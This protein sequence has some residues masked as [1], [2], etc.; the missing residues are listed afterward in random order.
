MS[1]MNCPHCHSEDIVPE[2]V[3]QGVVAVMPCPKCSQLLVRFRNK[4]IALN[5]DILANGSKEERTFHLAEVISEF[6]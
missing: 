4:M 1:Q 3:P 2:N 6:M 5:R